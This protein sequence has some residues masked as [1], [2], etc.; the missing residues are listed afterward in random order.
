MRSDPSSIYLRVPD[1]T[2]KTEK[3]YKN[4]RTKFAVSLP[5]LSLTHTHHYTHTH[6]NIN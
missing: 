5:S 2:V 1:H 4:G 3:N 6:I